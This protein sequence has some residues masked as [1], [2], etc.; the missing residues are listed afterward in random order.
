MLTFNELSD[1][2]REILSRLLNV[3]FPGQPQLKAQVLSSRFAMFDNSRSLEIFP[4]KCD[5]APVAKTIPVEAFASDCDGV[6]IQSLLFTRHGMA[7]MLEVIRE[8]GNEIRDL[9][10]ASKFEVIV[11]GV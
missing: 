2:Y 10:P 1:W 7:Y 9:P 3:S 8:D 6:L 11:L 5:A 4:L